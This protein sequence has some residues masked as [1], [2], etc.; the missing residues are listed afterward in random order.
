MT[1]KLRYQPYL[2]IREKEKQKISAHKHLIVS[3]QNLSDRPGKRICIS[4]PASCCHQSSIPHPCP[5]SIALSPL[6]QRISQTLVTEGQT[7]A[8]CT[9]AFK[10]KINP[11]CTH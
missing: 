6:T 1:Y 10:N 2:M 4:P 8:Q 3:L 9:C 11:P 5:S 7:S